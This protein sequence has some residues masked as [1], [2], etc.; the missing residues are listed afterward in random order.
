[1]NLCYLPVHFYICFSSPVVADNPPLFVLR[2]VLGKELHSMCCIAHK[3]KCPECMYNK[4]CAYAFLFETILPQ[5]NQIVPGRDRASHPFAFTQGRGSVGKE[6]KEYDFVITL[7]GK[8]IEYLPYVYAAFVRA[9]KNGLFKERVS[10]IVEKVLAGDRDILISQEQLDTNVTPLV[11]EYPESEE[12]SRA[13]TKKG[14]VLVELK[15]P[16]R[17]KV[18]G[19]YASDFTARDFM[20]CLFRRMN[21]MCSLYGQS[22]TILEKP[23]FANENIQITDKN[24]L[25]FQNRHYSARQKETMELGGVTGTFKLSGNFTEQDL[26]LL[27]FARI[28]NAGKNTNFGLGQLDFR[29]KWE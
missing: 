14:E 16:M 19:K 5:K 21:T 10:F 28:S 27:E 17:F 4:T 8:A 11:F 12:E 6:L 13:P 1:M 3:A 29:T 20:S 25:W 23:F 22:A 24:L 26:K 18:G 2:S 7:F 9:G 15:T